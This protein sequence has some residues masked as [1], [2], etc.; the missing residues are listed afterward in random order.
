MVKIYFEFL[1]I[2]QSIILATPPNTPKRD[3][4][5]VTEFKTITSVFSTNDCLFSISADIGSEHRNEFFNI[6]NDKHL[7]VM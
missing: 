4:H 5:I 1:K 2:L 6:D 3:K 7:Q